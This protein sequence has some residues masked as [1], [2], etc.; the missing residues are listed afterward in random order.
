MTTNLTLSLVPDTIFNF[1]T[2]NTA[3]GSLLDFG[4]PGAATTIYLLATSDIQINGSINAGPA[5]LVISTPGSI[6]LNGSLPGS[7]L[8]LW[9]NSVILGQSTSFG[10]LALQ[11]AVTLTGGTSPITVNQNPDQSVSIINNNFAITNPGGI[12]TIAP[13]PLPTT[14][15]LFIAGLGVIGLFYR[16]RITVATAHATQISLPASYC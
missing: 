12:I 14:A 16:R 10:G 1:T 13:T 8:T 2:L 7:N 4:A 11:S 5:S 9:A 3:T 15:L 6:T